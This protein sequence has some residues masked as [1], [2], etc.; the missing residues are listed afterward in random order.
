MKKITIVFR[1]KTQVFGL[2]ESMSSAGVPAK[3]VSAPKEAKIGCA[4]AV[5]TGYENF[6][7]IK[8]LLGNAPSGLAGV[9]LTEKRGDRTSFYRIM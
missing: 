3:I 8:Y 5:E 1:S 6:E 4:L 7:S 9:F 2:F